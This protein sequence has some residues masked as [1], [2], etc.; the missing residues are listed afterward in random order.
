MVYC[1]TSLSHNLIQYLVIIDHIFRNH[2]DAASDL[3]LSTCLS[4][5]WKWISNS[6]FQDDKLFLW[7]PMGKLIEAKWCIYA[8]VNWPPLVQIM[9]CRLVGAKPLSEPKLEICNWI[10]A[11]KLQWNLNQNLY[12]Y[13]QENASENV[14]WKMVAML[15]RP[16]CVNCFPHVGSFYVCTQPMGDDVT[17]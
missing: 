2:L 7:G 12:I 9:A 11:N 17:M 5:P 3:I 13:I 8:S 15:S 6:Y 14:V 1:L 16:Q 4:L 10:L